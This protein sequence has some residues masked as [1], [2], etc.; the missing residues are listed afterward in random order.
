VAGVDSPRKTT[1]RRKVRP[2]AG[3]GNRTCIDDVQA[4]RVAKTAADKNQLATGNTVRTATESSTTSSLDNNRHS[5][6]RRSRP[7]YSVTP[8]RTGMAYNARPDRTLHAAVDNAG[9]LTDEADGKGS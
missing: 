2:T 4:C 9:L 6:Q 5:A 7:L 3:A 8:S 1:A